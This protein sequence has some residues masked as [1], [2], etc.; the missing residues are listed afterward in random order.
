MCV[1][2]VGYQY[3]SL[4]GEYKLGIGE[5][6]VWIVSRNINV[7]SHNMRVPM[8]IFLPLLQSKC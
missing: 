3:Q 8:D 1:K 7:Q 4:V 2:G 5:S 6:S